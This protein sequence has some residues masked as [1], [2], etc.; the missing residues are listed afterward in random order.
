[1]SVLSGVVWPTAADAADLDVAG[2]WFTPDRSSIVEVRDCGD[3]TP[4]GIITRVFP[5]RGAMVS[6]DMNRDQHL[7]GRNLVGVTLFGGF[8]RDGGCWNEGSIYNPEN[9]RTYRAR[10]ELVSQDALA[11]SGCLGPVCKKLVW[12]RAD[13]VV[14]LGD[15]DMSGGEKRF[16][17]R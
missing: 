11:V 10:L 17:L 7:K 2:F 9:G 6:D 16:A 14:A 1:M 15:Q 5:E 8:E 13:S 4:C 12:Q 3:G